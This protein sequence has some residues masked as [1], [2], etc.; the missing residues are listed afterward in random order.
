MKIREKNLKQREKTLKVREEIYEANNQPK[1]HRTR[2]M[3]QS[4]RILVFERDNYTCQICGKTLKDGVKLEVDH[5]IPVSRGGSDNL[6]NLQTLCFDCNREKS[7]K[8]LNNHIKN[9]R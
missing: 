3:T 9:Q 8:I 7:D 6:N 1:I 2:K 5:I 4:T